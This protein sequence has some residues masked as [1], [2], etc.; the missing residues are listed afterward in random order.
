MLDADPCVC[1]SSVCGG[2]HQHGHGRCM[3]RCV[4]PVHGSAGSLPLTHK[5][6]GLCP[7]CP[8]NTVGNNGA[9]VGSTACN[10]CPSNSDTAGAVGSTTCTRMSVP[11]SLTCTH[12][13]TPMVA[14]G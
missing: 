5:D 8:I 7:A 3:R 11:L 10:A 1:A 14:C 9:G 2:N 4:V 12:T 13:H 6:V